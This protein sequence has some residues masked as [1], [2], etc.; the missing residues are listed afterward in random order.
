MGQIM[1]ECDCDQRSACENA[2]R[3][4]ASGKVPVEQQGN[5]WRLWTA[6]PPPARRGMLVEL[7][8]SRTV[9]D[10]RG[11]VENIVPDLNVNGLYWRRWL[12]P[13]QREEAPRA[14]QH[15]VLGADLRAGE[16]YVSSRHGLIP[17]SVEGLR[18]IIDREGLR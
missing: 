16:V 12:V 4:L 18:W 2:G 3:C 13:P 17:V 8:R 7:S 11:S 14:K 9:T 5:P 10:W 1:A 15:D 6:D